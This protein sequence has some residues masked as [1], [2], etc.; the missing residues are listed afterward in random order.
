MRA[1]NKIAAAGS[2]GAAVEQG[3]LTEGIM[4][5]CVKHG[6]PFVLAGSIRDDGPLP[7]TISDMGARRS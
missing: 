5:S 4:Y 3:I 6:V 1:I 2:I 7:D